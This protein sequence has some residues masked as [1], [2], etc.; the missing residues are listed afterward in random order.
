MAK[1]AK[2]LRFSVPNKVGVLSKV[3]RVLRDAKVNILHIWACGEGPKGYF[4]IVTNHNA[5]AKKALRKLGVS[6]S[7]GEVLVLK[8]RNKVGALD[9]IARRLA[10]AKVNLTCL[11]ATGGGNSVSVLIN[12]KNNRKAQR[13]V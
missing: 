6:A 3:T 10:N 1:K 7:E 4:G 5:R 9:R 2:E 8:L 11:S 12:T 13:I